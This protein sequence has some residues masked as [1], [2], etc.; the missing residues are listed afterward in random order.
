MVEER[1]VKINKTDPESGYM[2]RTGK[3]E[4]FF[5]LDHR[6]VDFK[7]NIITDVH[8]T[9]GNV[10]DA[11]PYIERL[12]RQTERFKF[13]VEAVAL[14]AGYLTASICKELQ[15][16]KIFAV[17]GNRRFQSTKGLFPKWKFTFDKANA[18]YVCPNGQDLVYRT[19]NREGYQEYHCDPK[20]CKS[21]PMLESC[22]RSK[23]HKKIITR[24]V[25][26]ESKEWVRQNRLTKSGKMLYKKRSQTIERSFADAKE[27]HGLR[28]CR[29]RG[30][31]HVQEQALL[32][33]ACQNMKKIANHLA[34]LA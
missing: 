19:T 24:H 8:I 3:P 20:I 29:F 25:W 1:E 23:T 9:A 11:S 26:E 15:A 17:I 33:A 6:T 27:L 2:Y 34:R 32:T 21:C 10:H 18:K 16:K 31:E 28:Y 30:R 14:D 22:T 5:Y 12:E 13:A 4:G 7:Y